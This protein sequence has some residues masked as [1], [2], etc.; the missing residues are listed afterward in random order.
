MGRV[1]CR[2]STNNYRKETSL[3][4]TKKLILELIYILTLFSY[5]SIL[6]P[7]FGSTKNTPQ[8]TLRN[9]VVSATLARKRCTGHVSDYHRYRTTVCYLCN[10]GNVKNF[11]P[12]MDT[13]SKTLEDASAQ[14]SVY[15]VLRLCNH[16]V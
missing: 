2:I 16:F 7:A 1:A 6:L 8:G 15:Y 5:R 12:N 13:S 10:F 14:F 9:R 11:A 4:N 3:S